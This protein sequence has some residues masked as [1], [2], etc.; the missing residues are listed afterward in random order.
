MISSYP[1]VDASLQFPEAAADM[2]KIIDV[3]RAIRARRAEMNVPPS[4]KATLHFRTEQRELFRRAEDFFLR[5]ASASRIDFDAECPAEDAVSIVTDAATVLIPMADM[6]DFDRERTR[7]QGELS[8]TEGEIARLSQKLQNEA[9]V[10][11][12]PAA[13]VENERQK[14]EKY[15]A[16]KEALEQALAK[17]G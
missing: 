9:F 13:V 5:L 4:K 3:I 12:A 1:R 8:K 7:L 16:T 6:I 14:L 11:R 15:Q 10:A 17:L 2:E